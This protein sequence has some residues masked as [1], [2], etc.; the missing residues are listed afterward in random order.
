MRAVPPDIH[1]PTGRSILYDTLD[2][3]FQRISERHDDLLCPHHSP[4][5]AFSASPMFVKTI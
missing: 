1:C 4:W 3:A 2:R 5:H